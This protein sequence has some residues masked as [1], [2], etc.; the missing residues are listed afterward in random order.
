[1]QPEKTLRGRVKVRFNVGEK[2][3]YPSSRSVRFKVRSSPPEKS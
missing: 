1:M 3:A 2:F